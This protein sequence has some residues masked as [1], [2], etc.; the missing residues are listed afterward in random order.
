[1]Y[2]DMYEVKCLSEPS[3]VTSDKKGVKDSDEIMK[4]VLFWMNVQYGV[5]NSLQYFTSPG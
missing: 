3:N 5:S 2:E 4:Y 1:M